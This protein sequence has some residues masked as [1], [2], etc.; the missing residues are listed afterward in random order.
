MIILGL[1][2]A[3]SS[4]VHDPSAALVVDGRLVAAYEEER[5]NRFKS[6]P[7]LFPENA[8]KAVLKIGGIALEDVDYVAVD[9][10]SSQHLKFKVERYL[11]HSFGYSP[12]VVLIHHAEAHAGGGFHSSSFDNAL[13]VSIDG[14][15]DMLSSIIYT[16]ERSSAEKNYLFRLKWP[17]SLGAFYTLFTNFL[18]FKSIEGEYKVM[19]MAAFGQPR[20]NL[21]SQLRFDSS[22][23][24]IK[25]NRN[26][27]SNDHASSIFEPHCNSTYIEGLTGV[28]PIVFGRDSFTQS[29]YDLAASV[30]R[31]F[32]NAYFE[33]IAH[34]VKKTGAQFL[35]LSGGCAL[36]CLAN[37]R[38]QDLGL[39]GIYVQPG[40]SDRGLSIG[41]AFELANKK[42][43]LTKPVP[44]MYLGY[45]YSQL[46]IEGALCRSGLNYTFAENYI[47]EAVLSLCSGKVVGWFQG[48]S[49]FG[50]RA[51]G[52]RSILA[53]A[54]IP[55]MKD[56]LNEK[57]KFREQFRPFAPAMLLEDFH[58]ATSFK[59][60]DDFP[61]MTFTFKITSEF[62]SLMS[63]AIQ[64]DGTAR[65]QTVSDKDC[66]IFFELLKGI[67]LKNGFGVLLNTSFNLAGEPIVDSPADA[68]RTFISSDIDELFIGKY[69]VRKQAV[70]KA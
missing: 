2:A 55:G 33:L 28:T 58:A 50:P 12:E 41:N 59:E 10:I 57:I 43:I 37:M 70:S 21:E 42:H 39:K 51:L 64:V 18:G 60:E 30:Q 5:L 23:E 8:I 13:V 68:L 40:A 53:S 11:K 52:H 1:H 16:Q 14:A 34:F 6:S 54:S 22:V 62:Q 38:L 29:H 69:I 63:E 17:D 9:G 27:W 47:D 7:G 26:L 48:R 46:E 44:N 56:K 19:G 3:F 15:G 32:E 45:E 66:P 36:N 65:V 31:T 25:F 24:Q 4:H 49:E 35:T 20:F 61:F 67:K